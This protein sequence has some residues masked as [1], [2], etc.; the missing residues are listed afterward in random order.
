[1]DENN[2]IFEND[3]VD[4]TPPTAPPD[5][6]G[7]D[8]KKAKTTQGGDAKK[9]K[10]Q[11]GGAGADEYADDPPT[12]D[13]LTEEIEFYKARLDSAVLKQKAAMAQQI[14]AD[15]RLKEVRLDYENLKKRSVNLKATA[16]EDGII[17]A[18]EKILPVA[19]SFRRAI[20]S[21]TDAKI[22]EG[23]KMIYRQL[24]D[25]LSSLGVEEIPAA[26][27]PFDPEKHNAVAQ[28]SVD[29]PEQSGLVTEVFSKGY[30]LGTRVIRHSQ[31]KVAKYP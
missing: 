10:A 15:E 29:D 24:L 14:M 2:L 25:S 18:I 22:S 17:K 5:E 8:A 1:M 31:V 21:I 26:G 16:T 6:R 7:G 3:P 30:T 27:Q 11:D 12:I 9:T 13:G 28:V 20:Y 23:L 4:E 19:D